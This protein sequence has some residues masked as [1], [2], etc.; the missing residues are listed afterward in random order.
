MVAVATGARVG[1]D[2]EVE[3]PRAR[4]DALAARVLGPEEHA[5]WLDVEP[6]GAA[7]R[8]SSSGGP[9]RR[10]TSRRSAPASRVPLRDVPLEPEG[11]TVTGF[12]SPPGTVAR[13]RGR[14]RTRS[15]RCESWVPPV[16]EA[17]PRGAP[18]RRRPIDK[19]RGTA[20]GSVLAAGLLGLRDALEPRTRREGRDRAGLRGRSAVQGSDRVAPRPR[21]SRGLDRDGAAVAARPARRTDPPRLRLAESR[22]RSARA[23]SCTRASISGRG[24]DAEAGPGRHREP[25]VVE[26]ERLGDVVRRSSG[27]TPTGRRSP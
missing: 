2:I 14:G 9:R 10:R 22:R 15:C 18:T 17:A 24:V 21:P 5:D 8:R 3:R 26:L 20:V 25:A 23:R 11:W 27:S 4:L 7:P 13:R 19:F 1:V 16:V 6:R 12:A